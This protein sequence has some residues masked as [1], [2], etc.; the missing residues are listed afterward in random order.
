M[1]ASKDMKERIAERGTAGDKMAGKKM[2]KS[3]GKGG[4]K[5]ERVKELV[6]KKK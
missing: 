4:E 6:K 3:A 5:M 2:E 1:K